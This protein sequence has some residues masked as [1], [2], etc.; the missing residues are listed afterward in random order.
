MRI[1][2]TVVTGR[3]QNVADRRALAREQKKSKT[4]VI[5]NGPLRYQ[6]AMDL[7]IESYTAI[8]FNALQH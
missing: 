6:I 7:E 4:D 8:Q 1:H 2:L 5:N 3:T